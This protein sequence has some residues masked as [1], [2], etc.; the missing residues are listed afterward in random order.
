MIGIM[1]ES[2]LS[3]IEKKI[4]IQCAPVIVGIKIANLLVLNTQEGQYAATLFHDTELTLQALCTFESKI[5]Y[6][7]YQPK[8][9]QEYIQQQ[10]VIDYLQDFGYITYSLESIIHKVAYKY[11]RFMYE[12][13]GFPHEIGLLLG[14]PL[15]DVSSFIVQEGNGYLY[16]G[17]WKVYD[18]LPETLIVFSRFRRAK[19]I[20]LRLISH[21]GKLTS[22]IREVI[23]YDK[24][25]F[26]CT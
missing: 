14:Y 25:E 7:L 5:Y 19:E 16:S 11:N 4:A 17:Y 12:K 6:L 22:V 3:E 15:K 20:L 26:C 1:D 24:K 8:R 21:G 10:V 13:K 2:V 18:N 23:Q 9:L